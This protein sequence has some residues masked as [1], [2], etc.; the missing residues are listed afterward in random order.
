MPA[1]GGMLKLAALIVALPL[2]AALLNGLL[3]RRLPRWAVSIAACGS[4]GGAFVVALVCLSVLLSRPADERAAPALATVTIWPW[5]DVADAHFGR[6][7]RADFGLL[8]DPLSVVMAL[9]VTGVGFLIHVYSVGYMAEDQ[10][11][12]RYFTYLNLFAASMLL[13]VL[14]SNF[15]LLFVG[16]ELVGL[17]S[18]LL[19]GFWFERDAAAAAGKKAFVVNRIGDFGFLLGVLAIFAVFG[20]V[21]YAEVFGRAPAMFADKPIWPTVI[22]L[23]L[24]VGATG[25]SAQIPLYVWL[26][27]AMEGPTPVSALIHAATMV[28]AGVYMVARC[29]MLYALAPAA[30]IVVAVIG[31]A[32]AIY[33][34]SIAMTQY[35]F[36]RVLAYSTI[37]Q[38]GYMLLACGVGAFA[39]GVFHLM[40]H[41]F[42]KA[43]LFL[44]AGSVMHALH[45]ELDI[46]R[47]GGLSRFMPITWRT[48]WVAAAA[49]SGLPLFSGFFS[50]DEI[51][52]S[53]F[54]RGDVLGV[55]CWALGLIGAAMTAF[56]V[57]RLY[58][59]V[60][61]G[62]PRVMEEHDHIEEAPPSMA[63][64][65]LVLSAL[66]AVGGLVWVP[67]ATRTQA[68]R[69]F[70][71]PVFASAQEAVSTA[72]EQASVGL[73]AVIIGL[74]VLAALTG[75]FQAYRYYVVR[76]ELPALA[77]ARLGRFYRL[78]RDK[79]RVDELYEAAFV[80]PGH[81]LAELCWQR[82]DVEVIDGIVNGIGQ[83]AQL[84]A[85]GLRRMQTGFV[86]D[87][88][89]A[90]AL[91]ATALV[92]YLLVR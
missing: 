32:T 22:A 30:M 27:D 26:P 73:E 75:I 60:F 47:M 28:T 66:A 23:L 8:V 40:T 39:A 19:I 41:A 62:E 20:T 84:L 91:G 80:R 56:Y 71:E 7:L 83:F 87:Y 77:A 24:F 81:R 92:I 25:K 78:V 45:G 52:W 49:I 57:F 13:L 59:R 10:D 46:R 34:A 55:A 86:R 1:D 11:Y 38:I 51:L 2:L 12:P 64:P 16:W 35:D 53:A 79:Y 70:L 33:A 5:L 67:F 88:A 31:A 14:A 69:M 85:Q 3:G 90:T 48:F 36:K 44:C 6:V 50:K 4:V 74:S 37:S 63:I 21:S 29:S 89:M 61:R 42:F 76:P 54:S 18:Y 15:L 17:C 72:H 68:F 82:G 43:L 65:L 9:V 58:Y